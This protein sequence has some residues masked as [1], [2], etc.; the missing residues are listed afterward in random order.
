M[1]GPLPRW[2]RRD[3]RSC[4][5]IC[6]RL[7]ESISPATSDPAFHAEL[8]RLQP[9]LVYCCN[10]LEH[11]PR[12]VLRQ[13]PEI[14]GSI[15]GH[16]DYLLITVP[17]SYPYHADPIDTLYRPSP[18][19]LAS[20]LPGFRVVEQAVVDSETYGEE[21]RKGTPARRARKILRALFPF[22]RPKRWLSHVHRFF[23]FRKPYR[24]TCIL[25]QR[26]ES[27]H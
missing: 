14:L 13:M 25:L 2:S 5:R 7:A 17:L 12:K 10:V 11:L 20:F 6:G 24:H 3:S 1:S 8:R 15:I 16:G 21:F 9:R 4:I 26:C 22:V 27:D 18:G 23:W 19:Q